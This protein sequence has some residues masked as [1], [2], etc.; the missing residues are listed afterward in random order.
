MSFRYPKRDNE[1]DAI[2]VLLLTVMCVVAISIAAMIWIA[3]R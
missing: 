3:V 2:T 1:D